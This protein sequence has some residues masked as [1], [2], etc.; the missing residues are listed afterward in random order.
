[1]TSVA[2]T[3]MAHPRRASSALDLAHRLDATIVWDTLNDEWHT[4]ARAWQTAAAQGTDWSL[5][6]QDDAE[7]IDHFRDHAVA[8]LEHAPAT[9]VSLYIGT[10]RP[11]PDRV[12]AAATRAEREHAAWLESNGLYW[13]VA[14]ALPTAHVAPML[15]WCATERAPYDRR[16]GAY[17]RHK[18]Q[19][20]VR[21]T[22]PSLVDHADTDSLV[23]H[24]APP[25]PRRAHHVGPPN[26]DGPTIPI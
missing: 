1:M 6:I 13:G 23:N 11:Q 22:W 16:I 24:T 2:I 9:A 20:R 3:V 10:G 12:T 8:V 15:T 4:G 25:I 17:Y 21:Y 7:P 5:V 19:R 18:L 26:L 14:I